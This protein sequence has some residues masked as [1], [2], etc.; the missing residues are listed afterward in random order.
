MTRL[1]SS[2]VR[3][4][5]NYLKRT[6]EDSKTVALEFIRGK[7][8]PVLVGEVAIYLGP[9]CSLKSAEGILSSLLIE[10]KIRKATPQEMDPFEFRLAYLPV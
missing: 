5:A 7:H 10:N 1:F 4:R 3:S 8:R 9:Y 2:Q 6:P